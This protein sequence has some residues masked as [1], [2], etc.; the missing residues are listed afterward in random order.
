MGT[1]LGNIYSRTTPTDALVIFGVTGD[2]AYKRIFPALYAMA[3]RGTLSV[4]VVGIAAPKWSLAQLRKQ[5]TDSIK[6]AGRIDDRDALD[7]LHSLLQY[8]DGDY[9]DLGTFKALKQVLGVARCPTHY[10]AIPPA[11]FATVINGLGAT[12]LADQ[13][14]VI[15]EKPY[16]RNPASAREFNRIA[17]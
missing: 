17:L 10:L 9:N 15:V 8:V 16:G 5:A 2:L 6:Q 12:G 14:R 1:E 7:H 4:P 11:L 13:A 3:K